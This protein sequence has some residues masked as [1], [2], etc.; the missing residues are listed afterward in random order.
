MN[1]NNM[2]KNKIEYS[3]LSTAQKNQVAK[4]KEKGLPAFVLINGKVVEVDFEK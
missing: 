2:A 1:V 4:I 3:K